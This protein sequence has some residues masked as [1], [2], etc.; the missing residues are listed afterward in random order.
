MY[1]LIFLG[2]VLWLLHR[3]QKKDHEAAIPS[4]DQLFFYGQRK[5]R[6][7]TKKGF[8]R[9]VGRLVGM[10]AVAVALYIFLQGVAM[11]IITHQL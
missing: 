1:F 10:G 4:A 8:F 6:R 11:V 9:S 7:G 5:P 3:Q 2:V